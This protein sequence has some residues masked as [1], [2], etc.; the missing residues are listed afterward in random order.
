MT[1]QTKVALCTLGAWLAIVI[2]AVMIRSRALF[3]LAPIMLVM[4]FGYMVYITKK[5]LDKSSMPLY[6]DDSE[7]KQNKNKAKTHE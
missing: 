6:F 4:I 3:L 5:V 1:K 2:L 7:K